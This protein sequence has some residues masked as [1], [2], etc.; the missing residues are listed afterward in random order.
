MKNWFIVF[1][2]FFV[3]ASVG[4]IAIMYGDILTRGFADLFP[5]LTIK[6]ALVIFSLVFAKRLRDEADKKR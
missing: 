6:V 5:A 3:N 2:E 4:L 1:S